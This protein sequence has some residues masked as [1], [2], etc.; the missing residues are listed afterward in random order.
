MIRTQSSD[1]ADVSMRIALRLA[2]FAPLALIVA[3]TNYVVDPGNM[4]GAD[5]REGGLA[6]EPL[7]GRPM[8]ATFTLDDLRLQRRLAEGRRRVPDVL[9]LGSSRTRLLSQAAFPNLEVVNASVGAASLEDIIALFELYDE[10]GLCPRALFVAVDAWALS[11]ALRNPSRALEPELHAALRRLD[12]ESGLDFFAWWPQRWRLLASPP[13]FQASLALI[14]SG[15]DRRGDPGSTFQP[16]GS[17]V[18]AQGLAKRRPEVVEVIV[19]DT[20]PPPFVVPPPKRTRVLLLETFLRDV[21]RRDV[22]VVLWL[23]PYHPTAYAR[24]IVEDVR[25][26]TRS[27]AQIRRLGDELRIPVLGSYDPAKS[28]VAGGAFIDF[29]HLRREAG[30]ALVARQLAEAGIDLG[31]ASDGC[32][33]RAR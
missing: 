32:Q 15:S 11:G 1:E 29:D 14:F 26:V 23:P 12:W 7:T 6:A 10:Q 19:R 25:G 8:T 4:F 18:W 33:P 16:D 2:A 27:E 31:A 21:Q 24:F 5:S 9:V 17:V 22:R 3:L 28:G 13:Y 20:P 30:N